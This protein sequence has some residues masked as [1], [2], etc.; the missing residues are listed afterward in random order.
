LIGQ[1]GGI[2]QM[3]MTTLTIAAAGLIAAA[4]AA[5]QNAAAPANS[6][7]MMATNTATTNVEAMNE[8]GG[9]TATTAN[10]ASATETATMPPAPAPEEKKSFPWGVIGLLGLI[11][12]IPRARRRG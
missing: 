6:V 10:T 4:P 11:G 12:L 9:M 8:T 7:D 1:Q 5:A 2:F 3:R